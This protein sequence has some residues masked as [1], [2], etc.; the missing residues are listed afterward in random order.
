MM[1]MVP[2]LLINA[3]GLGAAFLFMYGLKRMSSPSDVSRLHGQMRAG[4][5]PRGPRRR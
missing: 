1:T 2:Q 4:A 5:L 3:T